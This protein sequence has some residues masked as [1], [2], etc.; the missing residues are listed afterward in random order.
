MSVINIKDIAGSAMKG[1]EDYYKE[2]EN[3]GI[4]PTTVPSTPNQ[5]YADWVK[6]HGVDA[7]KQHAETMSALRQ[8]YDRSVAGYGATA[9]SLRQMGLTSSGLTGIYNQMANVNYRQGMDAANAQ[10]A[11]T[12]AA[13]KSAFETYKQGVQSNLTSH[14]SANTGATVD[15]LTQIAINLYGYDPISAAELAQRVYNATNGMRERDLA[16]EKTAN[17]NA[18]K[19]FA[20]KHLEAYDTLPASYLMSQ[21]G[22]SA[23]EANQ[24]V[25]NEYTVR[26][27]EVPEGMLANADG[28]MTGGTPAQTNQPSQDIIEDYN[29]LFEKDI[30]GES[31]ARDFSHAIDI[32]KSKGV[33]S[34][35]DIKSLE[36]YVA[37]QDA[38]AKKEWESTLGE[39]KD[40]FLPLID[41]AFKDGDIEGIMNRLA[42][43]DNQSLQNIYKGLRNIDTT[44]VE[45]REELL[46][47]IMSFAQNSGDTDLINTIGNKIIENQMWSY[48]SDAESGEA[49]G[50]NVLETLTNI[51][52]GAYSDGSKDAIDEQVKMFF[53]AGVLGLDEGSVYV[54]RSSAGSRPNVIGMTL[55]V[56]GRK[57]DAKIDVHSS[58]P[59]SESLKRSM[60]DAKSGEFATVED[61]SG[62]HLYINADGKWYWLKKED[63]TALGDG[64]VSNAFDVFV[65]STGG[66]DISDEDWEKV[67]EAFVVKNDLTDA[68][69]SGGAFLDNFSFN[70]DEDDGKD[71]DLDDFFLNLNVD[72]K[73]KKVE[74]QVPIS[75]S[76]SKEAKEIS[77]GF[78]S[79]L[80]LDYKEDMVAV[81]TSSNSY[82]LYLRANGRWIELPKKGA[83][84]FF[85]GMSDSEWESVYDELCKK[86]DI[87]SVISEKYPADPDAKRHGE[88]KWE[89]SFGKFVAEASKKPTTMKPSLGDSLYA[90]VKAAYVAMQKA[91]NK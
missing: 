53:D 65:E 58:S 30:N 22:I 15:E 57:I 71:G 1:V 4:L 26:G 52:N 66:D 75:T 5:M 83:T 20:N 27:M 48:R 23:E 25:T 76:R 56:G 54:T 62:R 84:G 37:E 14:A 73:N 79:L 51:A 64:V 85:D 17:L 32:L 35:A 67:W 72:G 44:T 68:V 31:I 24:I 74:V 38:L 61:E 34:D 82:A 29:K 8:T 77:N 50:F 80:G 12:E 86:Y 18:A 41:E 11:Q 7:D 43:S 46:N 88:D 33:Y 89:S 90:G 2:R 87:T 19:Q 70:L 59:Y 63:A 45:G 60:P 40:S 69:T 28:T 6:T 78:D 42:A 55:N 39:I 47:A 21:F 36:G 9:E 81:K 91:K 3:G 16:N 49:Q 13:N 10:K